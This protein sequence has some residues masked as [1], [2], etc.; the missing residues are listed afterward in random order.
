[1]TDAERGAAKQ[2]ELDRAVQLHAQA[3][4]PRRR[5]GLRP[6]ARAGG[7]SGPEPGGGR[8][9]HRRSLSDR[10]LTGHYKA[11]SFDR[12]LASEKAV[13]TA[14]PLQAGQASCRSR[15]SKPT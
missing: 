5:P 15:M 6:R 9:D 10:A 12:W 11:L 2:A 13:I 8:E 14:I 4:G 3:G 7:A 1:M